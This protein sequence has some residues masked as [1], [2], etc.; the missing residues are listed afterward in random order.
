[1]EKEIEYITLENK[2]YFIVKELTGSNKYVY[3]S[4]EDDVLDFFI[5]KVVIKNDEEYFVSLD[6][7]E[8]F[9]EAMSLF[10]K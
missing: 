5:Q 3:L 7:D 8:E 2:N 1:M 10:N 4:N 9:D 6:S